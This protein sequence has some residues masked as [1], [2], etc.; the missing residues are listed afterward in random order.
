MEMERS[1]GLA[2][3]L[4]KLALA[5]PQLV[6]GL[7]D[8]G[9]YRKETGK[10]K[11]ALPELMRIG[12]F[13]SWM[14]VAAAAFG[15]A[16]FAPSDVVAWRTVEDPRVSAD[17][18]MVV[19]VERWNDR[20]NLRIVSTD[21]KQPPRAIGDGPWRDRSPRWSPD[22]ARIAFLS[23]RDGGRGI[24][25]VP[26][27]GGE[28][29]VVST[30][31]YP[32][33]ALAWSP[34][35]RSIAFT[36]AG[37]SS[38]AGL[39]WA[40]PE[41]LGRL[42]FPPP[43][44]E[45]F[46]VPVD[47]G[48]PRQLSHGGFILRGEPAWTPAGDWILNAAA[49]AAEDAQIY[50]LRA[51][52]E[53]RQL[54]EG[55]GANQDPRPSPDGARI[56]WIC[57]AA[58][59]A[60]YSVRRLCVMGRDGEHRKVLAGALDR[61]ARAPQWS[62]DSRT[63]YFLA[64]DHGAT[65]VYAAHG[66]GAVRQVT[67]REER[68]EGFSLADNGRAVAVRSNATEGGDLMTF[69][70]DLPGGVTTLAE[71]N[72]PLLAQRDIGDVEEIHFESSGN[73]VQGW[74]V[75]PPNANRACPIPLVVEVSGEPRAM[76][77]HEFP[78]EAH[79]LAASGYAVLRVNPRGSPG[80]GEV[81]GDLLPTRLPGDDFDDLMRGVEAAVAKGG[82]DTR[83]V[84]LVG[85]ALAAWALGHTKRFG[86]VVA[87]RPIVDWSSEVAL[88]ADGWRR[89]AWMGGPPWEQAQRYLARSPLH[90]A[91]SFTTPTLVIGSDAQSQELYF[92]LQARKVESALL[93]PGA[94]GDPGGEAAQ[95]SAMLAWFGRWLKPAEAGRESA[96]GGAPAGVARGRA[97]GAGRRE[98]GAVPGAQELGSTQGGDGTPAGD[99][100][101]ERG[102]ALRSASQHP[103][104]TSGGGICRAR[105]PAFNWS[106]E[107]RLNA[108]AAISGTRSLSAQ[109][110]RFSGKGYH[111]APGPAL[112]PLRGR[113]NRPD[114]KTVL[115]GLALAGAPD[116]IHDGVRCH[117]LFSQQFLRRADDWTL[118]SV[119]PANGFERPDDHSIGN[120]HAI[121]GYQEVRLRIGLTGCVYSFSSTI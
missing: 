41:L 77:G 44:V 32:P 31:D 37:P 109:L 29:S 35:A 117:G 61:D 36:A 2:A 115:G 93:T 92:A 67:N 22:G 15:R 95:L 66:D 6:F 103:A 90:A 26:M 64:D 12:L 54:T 50:A 47:G 110:L 58:E 80:Y 111:P 7:W 82:I 73:T 46:V 88:D 42:R 104:E 63:L 74:L 112:A 33:L 68:L 59:P 106:G 81:F 102:P 105:P 107:S 71:P 21:G 28:P 85:G 83:R 91:A 108:I 19:Y 39:T 87:R 56:A 62:S 3:K 114:V 5:C 4:G 96:P 118:E 72:Q 65:H 98:D 113:E 75:W 76:F 70:V 94:E 8:Y 43:E 10:L 69:A 52:G 79:I 30:A 11:H 57:A 51:D 48:A 78:L 97:S 89:A 27:E 1:S 23:G 116:F 45:L 84:A 13:I 18:R 16:P 40:P 121:P 86:A 100:Q 9:V 25:I 101:G 38:A 99:L 120:V 53:T 24:H 14:M 34:D 55:P 20:A 17:G 119:L 49:R 60:F